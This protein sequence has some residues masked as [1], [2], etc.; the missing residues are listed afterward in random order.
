M[1]SAGSTQPTGVI[2]VRPGAGASLSVQ[3]RPTSATPTHLTLV[4]EN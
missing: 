1:V 2:V 4:R 3:M